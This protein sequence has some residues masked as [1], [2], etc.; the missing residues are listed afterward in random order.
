MTASDLAP[1]RSF[2]LPKMYLQRLLL[3]ALCLLYGANVAI[4]AQQF[5][6]H[7][8]QVYTPGLAI[9]DSPQPFTPEGGGKI[10]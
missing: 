10:A 7:H 8:G 1:L 3:L 6:V 9:L 4:L 5:A 2:D